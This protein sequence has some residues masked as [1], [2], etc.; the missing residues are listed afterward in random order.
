MPMLLVLMLVPSMLSACAHRQAAQETVTTGIAIAEDGV[1]I[2]YDVRGAGEPALVFVHCWSCDRTFWRDQVEVFA[3][4]HKVVT[5]DL[6]GHGESGA[7]RERWSVT[8][9]AGDVEAVVDDLGLD[10]IV[11]IGHSMGGPVSL[12][13]AAR[14]PGRV[15]AIVAV[16]TLHDAEMTWSDADTAQIVGAFENDFDGAMERFVPMLVRAEVEPELLEMMI[17]RGKAVDRTAA[18]ALMRDFGN[19][20]LPALF[21][22]AGAPIRAINAAP[23]PPMQPPTAVDTNRKYADFEVVLIEDVGHYV[24]LERPTTFNETLRDVLAELAASA[25]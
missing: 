20:D 19:L 21:T 18:V 11:L 5:L 2:A 9:L 13:A 17:D 3:R 12:A 1:P 24:Q 8:G 16:D 23:A 7:D 6:A 15:Q 25:R 14:M 22:A 10:Q 4:H